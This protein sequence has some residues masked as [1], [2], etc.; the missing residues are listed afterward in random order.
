MA[1]HGANIL[2]D[3]TEKMHTFR[4]K[5]DADVLTWHK[6][7]R[8]QLEIERSENLDLR[9]EINEMRA[10]VVRANDSLREMRRYITDHPEWHELRVQNVALRQ[11]K[12]FWKRLALPLLADDDSEFS[13]DDDLIDLEEKKR[14]AALEKEKK[15]KEAEGGEVTS[16]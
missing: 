5:T 9:N 1:C 6:N 4:E 10:G 3:I 16:S 15:L 14:L 11:E 2:A 8:K 13:D 7:Y 12:R